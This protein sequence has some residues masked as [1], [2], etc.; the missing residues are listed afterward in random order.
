MKRVV[1]KS[2]REGRQ[3]YAC[4]QDVCGFFTWIEGEPDQ[5]GQGSTGPTQVI[6][7]K[8][9]IGADHSVSGIH[10]AANSRDEDRMCRIKL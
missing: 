4:A 5:E 10:L 7:A 9:I 2:A 6:P 1:Q 3:F 8:R